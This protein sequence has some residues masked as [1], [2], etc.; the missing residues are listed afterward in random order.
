MGRRSEIHNSGPQL[1]PRSISTLPGPSKFQKF[2][3]Q[4]HACDDPQDPHPPTRQT[5]NADLSVRERVQHPVPMPVVM[6]TFRVRGQSGVL[7]HP[8]PRLLLHSYIQFRERPQSL[9]RSERTVWIRACSFQKSRTHYTQFSL[10]C[11]HRSTTFSKSSIALGDVVWRIPFAG[12]H[13]ASRFGCAALFHLSCLRCHAQH[14]ICSWDCSF[15]C[16][17]C[18]YYPE[19]TCLRYLGWWGPPLLASFSSSGVWIV[20]C[21]YHC[22]LYCL[23]CCPW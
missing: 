21:A 14:C 1:L 5:S 20:F 16:L 12:N 23:R 9:V 4:E 22:S 13:A 10:G 3:I 7:V 15:C 11:F 18:C 2:H 6:E 8:H 17:P 19:Q